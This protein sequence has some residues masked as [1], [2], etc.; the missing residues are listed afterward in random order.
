MTGDVG[1]MALIDKLRRE[2]HGLFREVLVRLI[3]HTL[4]ISKELLGVKAN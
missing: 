4:L 1:K 3:K 2:L